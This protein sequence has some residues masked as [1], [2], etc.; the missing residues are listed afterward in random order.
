MT[1]SVLR[2][3]VA[4]AKALLEAFEC[5]VDLQHAA[6][7]ICVEIAPLGKMRSSLVDLLK[8]TGSYSY[9]AAACGGQKGVGRPPPKLPC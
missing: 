9:S 1:V 5:R 4:C 2:A 3:E 6:L 8:Y 7:Q